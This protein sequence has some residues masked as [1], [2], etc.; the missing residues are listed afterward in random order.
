MERF[1]FTVTAG[2]A[3][4][5]PRMSV[6]ITEI[7]SRSEQ[8]VTR[9]FLCRAENGSLYYVKGR[10]AGYRA[11]CS[12]WV[13]GRLGKLMGLPIPDFCIAEVPR[14]LVEASDR[15]DAADLGSGL[16]FASSFV[17]DA[18]EITY[19]DVGKVDACLKLKV[20]LF[21]WWV[22][23]EDRTLTE[24]GGNPNLLRTAGAGQLHAIDLNLAFDDTFDE[25]RFWQSHIFNGAVTVW[26]YEFKQE[27]IRQMRAALE[28]LPEI[29]SELPD[30]WRNPGG[31]P[32]GADGLDL[33]MLKQR[34]KRFEACPEEFWAIR[35]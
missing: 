27:M 25:A 7:S 24:Y 8:G 2:F 18:Q 34:L 14:N 9:P 10:Y 11:L 22:R 12:E 30:E 3:L 1:D 6:T 35:R 28:K 16:V 29:W 26:P 4:I 13:G 32:G 15:A 17:E 5:P 21:D 23:N 19:A 31:H 20:M 33:A